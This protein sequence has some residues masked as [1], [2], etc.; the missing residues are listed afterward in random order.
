MRRWIAAVA[1]VLCA[2]GWAAAQ[3]WKAPAEAKAKK[4]PMARATGIKE[5]KASF[6]TSCAMCHGKTGKGDGPGAAAMNPKPK[7]LADKTIQGQTDGELFW[8]ISEGRGAMPP[9]KHLPDTVRW[10]LVHY[11]RSLTGKE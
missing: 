2:V 7:N 8:K 4:N 3:E 10:S 5:G 9:W 1:M 11:V 6:D